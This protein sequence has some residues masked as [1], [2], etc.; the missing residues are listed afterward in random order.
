MVHTEA[1][2]EKEKYYMVIGYPSVRTKLY[3]IVKVFL[4]AI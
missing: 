2:N 1:Q 4:E 3:Q